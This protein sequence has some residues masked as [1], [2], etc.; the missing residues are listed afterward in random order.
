MTLCLLPRVDQ[1]PSADAKSDQ[2]GLPSHGGESLP[3][4]AVAA[5]LT[6]QLGE[7]AVKA[8]FASA[9]WS[10]FSQH[11]PLKLST[12][13][14][15][16]TKMK[17]HLGHMSV[18]WIRFCFYICWQHMCFQKGAVPKPIWLSG[19]LGARYISPRYLESPNLQEALAARH[20]TQL[21]ENRY[22]KFEKPNLEHTVIIC[23][24]QHFST[25][26]LT[27]MF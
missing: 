14:L 7:T 1:H 15:L 10:G 6:R 27:I 22:D 3:R 12:R 18:F 11:P 19:F 21:S 2:N 16:Q 25:Q 8:K 5:S 24:G 20:C 4:K 26:S 13:W 23:K 17:Q 9:G